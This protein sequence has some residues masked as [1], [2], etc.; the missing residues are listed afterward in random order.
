MGINLVN[1]QVWG[2]SQEDVSAAVRQEFG[3]F[4]RGDERTRKKHLGFSPE[5]HA[6]MLAY[7]RQVRD[8]VG[9]LG[10]NAAFGPDVA[11][12]VG[13]QLGGWVGVYDAAMEGQNGK[14]CEAAARRLSE[15]LETAVLTFMVREGRSFL[16][17][18]GSGGV[19][20]DWYMEG[21]DFGPTTPPSVH[22]DALARA[23]ND[24][25][26]AERVAA[27][28]GQTPNGH[29][30]DGESADDAPGF[31]RLRVL[32][33]VLGI[34]NFGLGYR[35]LAVVGPNHAEGW[36]EFRQLRDDDYAGAPA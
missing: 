36:P 11:T 9:R 26:V 27:V 4:F 28:L 14:L 7:Q 30:G 35:G 20:L 15:K 21:P 12:L 24:L 17:V 29:E 33:G 2:R 31:H 5:E 1:V 8:W 6:Q 10:Y 19:S 22:G 32:A 25:G 34:S 16:Y 23:M 13:P 3:R 18:L